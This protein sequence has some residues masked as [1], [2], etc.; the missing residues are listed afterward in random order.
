VTTSTRLARL[1]PPGGGRADGSGPPSAPDHCAAPTRPRRAR[2]DDEA[3]ATTVGGSVVA[4]G[5]V[6]IEGVVPLTHRQGRISLAALTCVGD[7]G[8]IGVTGADCADLL[9]L[10][11]E[12]TGLAGGTGTLPFLLGLARLDADQVVVRQL[13]LTG[14]AGEA[15]LLE[16]AQPWL[17]AAG[18]VVTYNGKSFDVPLLVT[19][20]RLQRRACSLP[21]RHQVDLLHPTRSAFGRRWADCRLGTAEQ[22]LLGFTRVDDLPGALVPAVWS[23]LVRHGD[24]G[25]LRRVVAHNRDD[26]LTMAALLPALAAV[27]DHPDDAAR[28][29]ADPLAV[30]RHHLRRADEPA[31]LEHLSAA[32]DRLDPDGQL[33]LARLHRRAGHV[34]QALALWHELAEQEVPRA[35]EHLAKYHEHVRRDPLTALDY[36]QRLAEADARTELRADE[37]AH[38]C[39]RLAQKA[40]RAS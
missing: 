32:R 4:P 19:R 14:F 11:T 15:A 23:A 36:A 31:A 35:L 30:A 37:V 27:F 21:E 33:E 18:H 40:A 1:L 3:I 16:V 6:L 28:T 17:S 9:F 29:G 25:D 13:L 2:P 5:V 7:R 34:D 24:V 38:R 39:R 8:S 20:H 10:D 26:L 12:T 22:R